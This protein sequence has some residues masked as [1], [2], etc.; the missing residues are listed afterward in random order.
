MSIELIN[1]SLYDDANLKAY[2]RFES[3]ALTTDSSGEGHTLTAISDPAEDASG[4]FGGAV[5]LDGDDAYSAT[6]HADFKPTGNFT[7]G[8][9]VKTGN[10]GDTV[11]FQSYSVNTNVAG[12]KLWKRDTGVC[13]LTSGNNTGTTAPTNYQ[14]INGGTNIEDSA[15]HFVVGTWDGSNLNLYVDGASDATAVSYTNAPA[16]AATNYVR[17]G[18]GNLS[19]TNNEF[20]TGSLDDVFI[21]NGTALSAAQIENIWQDYGIRAETGTFTLTGIDTILTKALNMAASVGSFTLTGVDAVLSRGYTLVASVGEFTL[22]GIDVIFSK[23]YNLV[24]SVG[25]FTLTGIAASLKKL[26]I[27]SWTKPTKQSTGWTNPT[28]SNTNWTKP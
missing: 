3:G 17:V 28:K 27:F 12:I 10:T 22:T 6:D 25:E 1:H 19:G 16:Y 4:K 24:C 26:K 15:W 11:I 20:F 8:A 18:C 14:N 5:A 9:W 23:G 21:M 7:I 13:V 2:Y